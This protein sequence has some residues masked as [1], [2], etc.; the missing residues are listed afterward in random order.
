MPHAIVI[1][2]QGWPGL[3]MEQF[4]TRTAPLP[5]TCRTALLLYIVYTLK[6]MRFRLT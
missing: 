6:K 1:I 2:K 5:N 4:A 3:H